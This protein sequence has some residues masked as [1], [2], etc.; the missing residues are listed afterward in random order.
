MKEINKAVFDEHFKEYE[1]WFERN[2]FVYQS[3]LNAV[4]ELLP[5]VGTGLEV[6]VG[7]GRFAA[8]LGIKHGLEPSDEMAKIAMDNGIEVVKGIAEDLPFGDFSFDYILNVTAICFINDVKTSL[9]EANRVLKKGGCLLIGFVDLDSPLGKEYFKNK[10]KSLFYKTARFFS[11]KE[12][13]LMLEENNFGFFEFRQTVFKSLD[14]IKSLE[15]VEEGYGKGSFVV[16]K[17]KK[18]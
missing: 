4:K 16:I 6:G 18:L 10:E 7:T 14:Q 15:N 1:D 5:K 13:L 2:N 3:E 17:A 8:P 9:A 11:T 12:I